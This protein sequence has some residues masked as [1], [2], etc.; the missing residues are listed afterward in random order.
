MRKLDNFWILLIISSSFIVSNCQSQDN[1]VD[2][3]EQCGLYL[4]LSS[5]STSDRKSWG[6]Y[7]GKDYNKLT[8]VGYPELAINI[9]N[10]RGHYL[11][12]KI[13]NNNY[14]ILDN[15]IQF[16]E[17][18]FWIP[19]TIGALHEQIDQ[20]STCP[21]PGAGMLTMANSKLTNTMWS[22]TSAYMRPLINEETSSS[23]PGRGSI[24]TFHNMEMIA[25][26]N[27]KQGMEIFID[28]GDIDDDDNINRQKKL[29]P[30]DLIKVDE[31]INKLINYF[32]KHN[33]NLDYESKNKLYK[34]LLK[35]ILPLAVGS[36]KALEI[37]N[38]L[39]MNPNDLYKI[40][41]A[42][43]AMSYNYEIGYR[44]IDWL[45]EFGF[46]L[47]NIR[48]GTSTIINAGRGA[49]ATRAIL[50][51]SVIAPNPLLHF[52]DKSIFDMYKLKKE[53]EEYFHES[54]EII[55]KQVLFNYV[56]GHPESTMTFFPVG[57]IT[58]LINH[59]EKPNA[60]LVWSKN[61][62]NYM[63]WMELAPSDLMNPK[64]HY[65][66]L[67]M[68]IVAIRDIEPNEEIFIDY[69]LE[70]KDA[71][72][73]HVETWNSKITNGDVPNT[74]PIKAIDMNSIHKTKEFET[75]NE[76]SEPYPKNIQLHAFTMFN[77][78][79][80]GKGTFKDPFV[81]D[82]D[83]NND[84]EV[85]SFLPEHLYPGTIIDRKTLN[86]SDMD[87]PYTYTIRCTIQQKEV[88]MTDV[89]HNALV[90]TDIPGTSD[91]FYTDSFRHYIGIPDDIFP[92]GP[93]RNA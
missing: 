3:E 60:K 66:G 91:Q 73:K 39:P 11:S 42:G 18:L 49:F 37:I 48:S 81:W 15:L 8:K 6:I 50:K 52:P 78:D 63:E 31:L 24:S 9:H 5:T 40:I 21:I 36:Y 88:Y 83:G 25:I 2:D 71:W 32:N 53:N 7:A 68:E 65:V 86:E 76:M 92:K 46:C 17:R 77:A 74:W 45:K 56:Y 90:F 34:F 75:E 35:E 70:W 10:I 85:G 79:S 44:K 43:G 80:D 87:M 13:N 29:T 22:V 62:K 57:S 19:D 26:Q 82:G 41:E 47:D 64:Y 14:E 58:A 59:S 27:I 1:N 30:D 12:N 51:D 33:D 67:M 38:F 55:T 61:E 72:N 28:V 93:W 20:T 4:A 16:Y 84:D 54:D 69:G 89:P 23:Y